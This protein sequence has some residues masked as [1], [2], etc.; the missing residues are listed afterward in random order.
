MGNLAQAEPYVGKYFSQDYL[1]REILRQT[2]DEIVE[3]NKIMDK[4][5]EAGLYPDP[6]IAQA[7]ET[8]QAA[9]DIENTEANTAS[10]LDPEVP[11]GGE[12]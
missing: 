6:A 7:L 11:E 3:Q 1:R 4:E 8:A 12:I 9:A 2:D 10:T 5:I